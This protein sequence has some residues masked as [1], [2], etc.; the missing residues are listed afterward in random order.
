MISTIAYKSLIN[1]RIA[2]EVDEFFLYVDAD[3]DRFVS[4]QELK[5]FYTSLGYEITDEELALAF[6]LIDTNGDG[7]ISWSEMYDFAES[8]QALAL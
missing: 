7:L 8:Q 2:D 3:H 6:L 4:S 5:N 1:A